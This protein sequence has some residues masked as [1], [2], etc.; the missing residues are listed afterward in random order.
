V[1]AARS[2]VDGDGRRR[3]TEPG[4]VEGAT[5]PAGAARRS[6]QV[7]LIPKLVSRVLRLA[8]F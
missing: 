3:G 6:L 1:S 8:S 4:V 7:A 5:T 2:P